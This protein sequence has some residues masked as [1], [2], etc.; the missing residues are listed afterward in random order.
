M[1]Y[2][3]VLQIL[4]CCLGVAIAS[5]VPDFPLL[6]AQ[7]PA[8]PVGALSNGRE[9]SKAEQPTLK[10]EAPS[11]VVDVIVTDRDGRHVR[12]LSA[13][14][15]VIYEDDRPQKIVTFVPPVVASS[16]E[17]SAPR[18]SGQEA[19]RGRDGEGPPTSSP[20]ERQPLPGADVRFITIVMDIGGLQ[21]ANIKRACDAVGQ[22]L[23]KSVAAE[24]FVAI[25]W[26]DQSL[27]LLQ[28]FTQDKR[29][30]TEA[31]KTLT[32]HAPGGK[33]SVLARIQTQQEINDL[34]SR[35]YG[36]QA[37]SGPGAGVPGLGS[38][39]GLGAML[40]QREIATLRTFLWTQSTLQARSV[41]AA[42]RAIAQSYAGI[43]GRKN[44][45][46]FSQGFL[47]SPEAKAEL[48]AV[49][50]AANRANVAYYIVD[51][52]GLEAGFGAASSSVE[53]TINQQMYELALSGPVGEDGTGINKFDWAEHTG[54]DIQYDDLGQLAAATGGFL[55]KNQNDL[56][57]GLAKVDSDLRE[58]Y[59]LVYQPTNKTYDG[60]F[61][62]IKVEVLK[63]GLH[64]RHRLG[65]WA[66]PPGQ[67]VLLTPGSAQLLAGVQSGTLKPAF[68]P[69]VNAVVLLTP[70][71]DLA[72]P[73]HVSLP[74]KLVR[75]KKDTK[76]DLYCAGLTLLLVG[77]DPDRRLRTV[78]QRF[79]NLQFNKRQWEDFQKRNSLDIH[80]RLTIPKLEPLHVQA[81]LQFSDGTLAI[82]E[83]EIPL[84][85]TEGPCPGLTSVLL[86]NRVEEATGLADPSDP[87]RGSNYQLYLPAQ[88]RFSPSD[89]LTV[90]FGVLDV[91]EDPASR[92]PRLRL[93]FAIKQGPSTIL[94]LPS[95]E[96]VG[97][98]GQNHLLVL[99]QFDLTKLRP[100]NYTFE[101]EAVDDLLHGRALQLAD[102]VIE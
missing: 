2:R 92:K 102:F 62:R 86:S 60:S 87:L 55:I 4:L 57:R 12:G 1:A 96:A 15:F 10:V 95:E 58:F 7:T 11:V 42:L 67:E 78:H 17:S 48:I 32:A 26:V 6:R 88:P 22:Y 19:V 16:P 27:H 98:A 53:P 61:R 18:S 39:S 65:Y 35:L 82:G 38:A 28:P 64:L 45:V 47:H 52:A 13:T 24:D 54:L 63:P 69:E 100:G 81:I 68:A 94:S 49:I 46:V 101:V 79:V 97:A 85:A 36:L 23:E 30:A 80:A 93:S 14:D 50:D 33:L 31:V 72:A 41:F 40:L 29:L 3:S 74:S 91:P 34:T 99:K 51:A 71:G 20:S 73:V 5:C 25:Y 77:R 83:H 66:I 43:P 75:F 90:Y 84:A 37:V 89:K 56:L 70:S 8:S 76:K 44:V 59:T 21:P 9:A